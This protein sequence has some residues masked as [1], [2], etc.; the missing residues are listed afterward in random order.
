VGVR[1]E[2][3]SD[4]A[5]FY[6][7][8]A[9]SGSN[10]PLTVDLSGLRVAI[11]AGAGGIGRVMA[12]AFAARGALVFVCDV[13]AESLADCPHPKMRADMAR[14]RN[15]RPSSKPPPPGSAASTCW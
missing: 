11:S 15:A 14:P 6:G 1:A 9:M 5:A 4:L 10:Q 2:A 13:D 3:N 12:D 8:D 7:S